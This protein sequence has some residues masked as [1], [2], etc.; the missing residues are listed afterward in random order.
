MNC[1]ELATLPHDLSLVEPFPFYANHHDE[2]HHSLERVTT[3]TET[4]YNQSMIFMR[5]YFSSPS[6]KTALIS[7]SDFNILLDDVNEMLRL[8]Q[9]TMKMYV[10]STQHGKFIYAGLQNFSSEFMALL[11]QKN[12]TANAKI[13]QDG[14]IHVVLSRKAKT[15]GV[16]MNN[17]HRF[18]TELDMLSEFYR[19]V[20]VWYTTHTPPPEF[21]DLLIRLN[22]LYRAWKDAEVKYTSPVA[23]PDFLTLCMKTRDFVTFL[24]KKVMSESQVLCL[25][26]SV[27]E[28]NKTCLNLF[29]K[30][31]V[32]MQCTSMVILLERSIRLL[33]SSFYPIKSPSFVYEFNMHHLH[34][35]R[36]QFARFGPNSDTTSICSVMLLA[37]VP[38]F[39]TG[40]DRCSQRD[41]FRHAPYKTV[42]DD[43]HDVMNHVFK[44][45]LLNDFTEETK[46]PLRFYKCLYEAGKC[47]LDAFIYEDFFKKNLGVPRAIRLFSAL[48]HMNHILTIDYWI[49]KKQKGEK[50]GPDAIDDVVACQ[51]LTLHTQITHLLLSGG[52]KE[53]SVDYYPI[54]ETYHKDYNSTFGLALIQNTFDST[55]IKNIEIFHA[56]NT[57]ACKRLVDMILQNSAM[58]APTFALTQLREARNVH[59]EWLARSYLPLNKAT[60]YAVHSASALSPIFALDLGEAWL[61][62]A[63]QFGN[64]CSDLVHFGYT[65]ELHK[66]QATLV[67]IESLITWVTQNCLI[68]KAVL[69]NDAVDPAFELEPDANSYFSPPSCSSSSPPI[70]CSSSSS[71][72]EEV[73]RT[74]EE[75]MTSIIQE[76]ERLHQRLETLRNKAPV[77][78]LPQFEL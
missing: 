26:F 19:S 1:I 67:E 36:E 15:T 37:T 53:G 70:P 34:S 73:V 13:C 61:G 49:Q 10:N 6:T 7:P 25:I 47:L 33:L 46:E 52:F 55:S 45:V 64:F 77:P 16:Q 69:D 17:P 39:T 28:F 51:I 75:E 59:R 62:R 22:V 9:M 63:A 30:G 65:T 43:Y 50:K 20:M 38:D 72:S 44:Y 24:Q 54:N 41:M 40:V 3:Q 60:L 32:Q 66:V 27:G 76:I 2:F 14:S 4:C 78:L 12:E 31:G 35:L 11:R 71:S 8:F 21:H 29:K 5:T 23:S 58:D 42:R 68:E 74:D 57:D 56:H 48:C 18:F